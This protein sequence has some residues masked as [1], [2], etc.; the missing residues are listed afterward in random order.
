MASAALCDWLPFG[1]ILAAMVWVG[2]A[3]LLGALATQVVRAGEPGAVARFLGAVRVIGPALLA[4][5]MLAV[6]GF[7][8]WLALDSEAWDFEQGWIQLGVALFAVAFLVGIAH[9][10]R[11]AILAERAASHGDY[12]EA[13]RQ[14]GRWSRATG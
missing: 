8:V 4:P 7:G 2:G 10:S 13:R 14:L 5:A 1:H 6:L 11:A 9:Q 12:E 3:I